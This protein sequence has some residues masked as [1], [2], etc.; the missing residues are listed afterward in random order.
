MIK[1]K[2]SVMES[3]KYYNQ[4]ELTLFKQAE[5]GK[6]MTPEEQAIVDKMMREIKRFSQEQNLQCQQVPV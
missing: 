5:Q 2:I 3:N 1:N 4:K 6:T